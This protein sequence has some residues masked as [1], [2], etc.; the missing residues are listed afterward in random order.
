[1]SKVVGAIHL[2]LM[3]ICNFYAFLFPKSKLDFVFLFYEYGVYLSWTLFDGQ[4][5]VSYDYRQ[6]FLPEDSVHKNSIDTND[7]LTLFG[8]EHHHTMK[9]LMY[10]GSA[11]LIWTFVKVFQ[12]NRIPV[13][14]GLWPFPVYYALT[15][16]HNPWING[17][18]TL[19]FL[20][21]LVFTVQK[22]WR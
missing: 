18:F 16:A 10:V 20:Y 12:R 14:F 21:Y 7:V 17:V 4:C 6:W 11:F 13:L 19:V 3:M 5:P 22:L 1:M 15:Y 9:V 8:D 2:V